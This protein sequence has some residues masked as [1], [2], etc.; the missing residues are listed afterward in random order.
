VIVLGVMPDYRHTGV[1]A[2]LYQ[3]HF[4]AAERKVTWREGLQLSLAAVK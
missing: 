2:M 1:A 3:M 4:D